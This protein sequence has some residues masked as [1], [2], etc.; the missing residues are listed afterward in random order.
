MVKNISC[1]DVTK[2]IIKTQCFLSTILIHQG[3]RTWPSSKQY[4]SHYWHIEM[5]V[6]YNLKYINIDYIEQ[7]LYYATVSERC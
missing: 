5:V 4:L 1:L 6:K 3:Y 7:A 2:T